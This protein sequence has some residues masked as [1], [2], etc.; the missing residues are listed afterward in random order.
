M[1]KNGIW[2]VHTPLLT[3]LGLLPRT[4]HGMCLHLLRP[5]SDLTRGGLI[6]FRKGNGGFYQRQNAFQILP[7]EKRPPGSIRN[8]GQFTPGAGGQCGHNVGGRVGDKTN[9][10]ITKGK[11]RSGGMGTPE[12]ES[13]TI[14]IPFAGLIG[15]GAKGAMGIRVKIPKASH[16]FVAANS[17]SLKARN[18]GRWGIPP[19]KI[20]VGAG[21]ALAD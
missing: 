6:D 16:L 19:T 3:T 7:K 10:A 5:I 11:V 4:A 1:T 21:R 2:S 12:V 18:G 17:K 14:L 8:G 20:E 15:V 13:I 9:R